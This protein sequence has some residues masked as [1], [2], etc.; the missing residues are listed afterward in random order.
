M[1]CCFSFLSKGHLHPRAEGRLRKQSTGSG[2]EP[3]CSEHG[4][5]SAELCA[6]LGQAGD[7]PG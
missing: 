5:A 7:L 4:V 3:D 2:K 6:D 1:S